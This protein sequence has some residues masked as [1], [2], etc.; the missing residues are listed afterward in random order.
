MAAAPDRRRG[1]AGA[2]PRPRRP[3]SSPPSRRNSAG[4][5]GVPHWTWYAVAGALLLAGYLLYRAHR[6][7]AASG[8]QVTS[9]TPG[10]AGDGSAAQQPSGGAAGI[11][12]NLPPLLV[13]QTDPLT[14]QVQQTNA[15]STEA[16]TASASSAPTA[17]TSTASRTL[18]PAT[19]SATGSPVFGQ[20]V[21]V[22]QGGSIG[23][24]PGRSSLLTGAGGKA[25][26]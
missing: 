8:P 3:G 16:P 5:S 26:L 10:P 18:A 14:G 2:S 25:T 23:L 1:P 4:R 24:L 11:P 12:G 20:Q 19:S 17:T 7:A 22:L 9:G 6:S 15:G 13:G 21:A